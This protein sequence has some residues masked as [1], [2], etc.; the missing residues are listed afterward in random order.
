AAGIFRWRLRAGAL[1]VTEADGAA[2]TAV[3]RRGRGSDR[4]TRGAIMRCP[5]RMTH[6]LQLDLQL[7]RWLCFVASDVRV[8][9]PAC[10]RSCRAAPCP[11][12][13]SR[14]RLHHALCRTDCG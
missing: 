3:T 9:W 11:G 8:R 1:A 13:P 6:P 5:L 14:L 10:C 2:W 12:S 7:D 4:G